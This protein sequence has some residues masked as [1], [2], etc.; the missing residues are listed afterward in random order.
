M[1]ERNV[2]RAGVSRPALLGMLGGLV[3]YALIAL[4]LDVSALS[5]EAGR[6]VR[7][8]DVPSLLGLLI[9]GALYRGERARAVSALLSGLLA[10]TGVLAVVLAMRGGW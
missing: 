1:S 8:F 9:A 2:V 3:A 10:F 6:V 5:P 4:I 7:L